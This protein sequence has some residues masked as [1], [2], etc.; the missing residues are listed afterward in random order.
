MIKY[1]NPSVIKIMAIHHIFNE[2]IIIMVER[3]ERRHTSWY[4]VNLKARAR[5][6]M[7]P[8]YYVDS[9]RRIQE[10]DPLVHLRGDRYMSVR[11]IQYS[12]I[13]DANNI[14]NWIRINLSAYTILNSED[15]YNRRSKEDVEVILDPDIVANKKETELIFVPSVHTLAFRKYGE[16]TL[17]AVVTFL[18]NAL[19]EVAGEGAFDVDIVKDRDVLNKILTSYKVI[20]FKAQISYSNPGHTSGFR[21]QFEGKTRDLGGNKLEVNAYGSKDNPLQKEPDGLLQTLVDMSE[22]NGTV[23]ATIQ[24]TENSGLQK[25]DTSKHPLVLSVLHSPGEIVSTIYNE[26][27]TRFSH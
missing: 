3:K 5:I 8:Q 1:S 26:L 11:S 4:A 25:I 20:T 6:N 10:V 23:E 19:K 15:F 24:E 27:K 22:E 12:E 18:E 2:F 13:H 21:A 16:L 14:P 9:I 17:S 7:N